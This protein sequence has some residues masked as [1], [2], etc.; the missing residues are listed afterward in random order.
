M[1]LEIGDKAPNFVLHG[2]DSQKHVLYEQ[3]NAYTVLFFYPKD[4]TPGC[5]TESCDFNEQLNEFNAL[6]VRIF[7]ISKDDLASHNRFKSKYNLRY[8]LL[9]D[10]ELVVH[11]AYGA[12][13]E[14][15]N[16]GKISL[17]VIRTTYLLDANKAIIKV[18]RKVRV[19]DH[20]A[21][22]FAAIGKLAI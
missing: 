6:G 13:G 9:S 16:Y 4:M 2:D 15:T 1:I 8:T 21:T 17:G 12:F 5:T 7:G 20:A 11:K 10:P 19:Q 18:W 3:K 22:V 14:K